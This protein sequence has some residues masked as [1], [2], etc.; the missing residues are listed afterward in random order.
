M[1]YTTAIQI[2]SNN[3]CDES[4]VDL[5][6]SRH[7]RAPALQSPFIKPVEMARGRTE[8]HPTWEQKW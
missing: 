8:S 3:N 2:I 5:G 1:F 4:I 6:S 7:Q